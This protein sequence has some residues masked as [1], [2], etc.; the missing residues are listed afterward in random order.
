MEP[1]VE[2]LRKAWSLIPGLELTTVI[3][4]LSVTFIVLY[5]FS[6]RKKILFEAWV[7]MYD[8][9]SSLGR[10]V[11]DRLLFK[12]R[13]I[14]A[15]HRQTESQVGLFNAYRDVPAFSQ[16][17]DDD[18]KLMAS[19]ELGK[20]SNL[21]S[22]V[23]TLL[24]KLIPLVLQPSG[25]KGS[26]HR[27][28]SCR[29]FL[30]TL[31]HYKVKGQKSTYT[32]LWEV[33]SEASALEKIPEYVDQLAYHIYLDLTG[34]E[35]FKTW[36]GFRAYT[37]GISRYFDYMD[38][39][40]SDDLEAAQTKYEEAL[41][42]EGGK[43]GTNAAVKY[44][45]GVLHY[46]KYE[47]GDNELAKSY[48]RAATNSDNENLRAQAHSGLANA[49]TQEYHRF[50][51]PGVL[52]EAIAHARAAVLIDPK[53]DATNK[54]LA[55]A[56]HQLAERKE[57][58]KTENGRKESMRLRH[59][60]IKH[61]KKAYQINKHHYI[62]HNNLGNLYLEWAKSTPSKAKA[63]RRLDLGRRECLRSLEIKPSYHHAHDNL[64]NIY[65]DLGEFEK[66][67]EAYQ[68][69]LRFQPEYPEAMN[70]LAMLH[71][72]LAMTRPK[73][74]LAN[75]DYTE[76]RECHEKAMEMVAESSE[77]QKSKLRQAFAARVA[78]LRERLDKQ[79]NATLEAWL[80]KLEAGLEERKE[81]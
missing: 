29:H 5:F 3:V 8:E 74:E 50:K 81:E 10:S 25:L 9:D 79:P 42:L 68:A 21:V 57:K 66:A 20:H 18:I 77:G 64:G 45:L 11:A 27:Y 1:I 15:I 56:C 37:E 78:E 59:L 38:L 55:F 76:A 6:V 63:R 51:R 62:A 46:F 36:Q 4:A 60:A 44:N 13:S 80:D 70:D 53:K 33:E 40:R 31:E 61:Y 58:E 47:E 16:G 30:V 17:L 23:V 41:E 72:D 28:G 24:F 54:A 34:G 22:Q 75:E 2:L 12:I 19:L 7:N 32:R 26:I 73:P 43:N 39:G 71:L 67:R 49:M 69:A 14:N 48:F 35:L 65:Y 52:K